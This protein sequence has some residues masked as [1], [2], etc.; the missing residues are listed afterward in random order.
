MGLPKNDASVKGG[1][2]RRTAPARKGI[3]EM[4]AALAASID[5]ADWNTTREKHAAGRYGSKFGKYLEFD[6]WLPYNI[7]ICR[8]LGLMEAPPGRLL[9]IGCLAGLL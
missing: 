6:R 2:M 8:E 4:T 5:S 1:R 9:D 3:R 7:R